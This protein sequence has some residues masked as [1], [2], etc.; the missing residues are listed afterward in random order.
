MASA[1]QLGDLFGILNSLFSILAFIAVYRSLR[2]DHEDRDVEDERHKELVEL[3]AMTA[4]AQIVTELWKQNL[5]RIESEGGGRWRKAEADRH[6]EL[7][8][9]NALLAAKIGLSSPA[10]PTE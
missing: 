3:Q 1:G 9:V 4:H 6:K 10:T 2:K 7:M 8:A 5:R